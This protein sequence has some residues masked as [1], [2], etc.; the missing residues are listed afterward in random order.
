MEIVAYQL[1]VVAHVLYEQWKDER[2]IIKRQITWGA[3]KRTILDR[4]LTLKLRERK[5]QEFINL[6]QGGVS[7]KEYSLK[8]T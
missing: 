3:F 8:F 6:R 4:F 2:P 1:N 7:M 5:I